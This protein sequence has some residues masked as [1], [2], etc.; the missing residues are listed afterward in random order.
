M[1]AAI[2]PQQSVLETVTCAGYTLTTLNN[3]FKHNLH[4]SVMSALHQLCRQFSAIQ[5]SSRTNV[6]PSSSTSCV[7]VLNKL[8]RHSLQI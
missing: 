6:L 1:T 8:G 7:V 5:F 2:P 4:V 3:N